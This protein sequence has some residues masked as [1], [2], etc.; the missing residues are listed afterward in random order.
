MGG[1]PA[2]KL[3][4]TR[5]NTEVT[6]VAWVG[7][8]WL[9]FENVYGKA[10][11]FD[12]QLQIHDACTEFL[13]NRD[14]EMN[15]EAASDALK[16][17]KHA[18]DAIRVFD[19]F[20]HAQMS[21]GS[22]AGRAV[23]SIIRSHLDDVTVPLNLDDVVQ[24]EAGDEELSGYFSAGARE[25]PAVKLSPEF[26]SN[27]TVQLTVAVQNAS[28][29]VDRLAAPDGPGFDHG[30]ALKTWILRMREILRTAG[31]PIYPLQNSKAS[32]FA[33]LMYRLHG[34]LPCDLRGTLLSSE[35]RMGEKI[36]EVIRADKAEKE[37][38]RGAIAQ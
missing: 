5:T 38:H 6:E 21:D 11:A 35:D 1:R 9:D 3:W 34:L 22:D 2:R 24:A 18:I 4:E 16:V 8:Q 19:H 25:K 26:L 23:A 29:E 37:R 14:A 31:L 13:R 30:Y 17:M 32:G 7:R 33:R 27:L 36:R 28:N 12:V 10:I 20:A 15:A